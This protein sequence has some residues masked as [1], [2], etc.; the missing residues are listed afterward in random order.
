M[1]NQMNNSS[2]SGEQKKVLRVGI[3]GFGTIGKVVGQALDDG[4]DGMTLIAV[5]SGNLDK[6]SQNMQGFR[7]PA[8]VVEAGELAE[9]V[10]VIVE[11]APTRAFMDVAV[12]ALTQGKVLVTVSGAAILENPQ[13]TDVAR[14]H[15]GQIVLATG[16]LLGLD[17][18]RAAAEGTIYSVKMVTRKPPTSLTKAKYVLENNI[19]LTG[20]T[21]PLQLFNGSA[22]EGAEK[23]P[24]NVNVAASLGLA[25]VGA[26]LTQL[27][28]WADPTKT[29]NTHNIKV[30]ADSASFELTIENVPTIENPGTGRITALSVIAALKSLCAPLRVGS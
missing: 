19:D 23:F 6:A 12:P 5:T 18:V 16:A 17:A 20:L 15:G 24:S 7:Q 28:I 8:K 25:G 13:I 11:C 10:D 30:D 26:D 1:K 21:E 22:R 2:E 14:K 3:A 9:L 27:E 29:R 4:I